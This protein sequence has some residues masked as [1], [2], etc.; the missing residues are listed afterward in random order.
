MTRA[1]DHG[2]RHAPSGFDIV[3][4][5]S[6]AAPTLRRSGRSHLVVTV[7]DVAWHRH[8]EATT[9]RGRRWHEFALT[10][11]RDGEA[12]LVVP[13]RLVAA[14]LAAFGVDPGRI[15]VVPG[16]A[17]HLPDPDLAA[18]EQL[19]GGLGVRGEFLLT[20]GT[21]EPRKN[22]DR[23]VRAFDLVRPS[24][25]EPWPLVIV[26]TGRVGPGAVARATTP[27]AVVFAGPVSDAVLAG[28]YRRARAFAYVP[29]TEGYGLP[30]LEAMQAGTPTVVSDEVP[31]V[32]DLGE[33]AAPPARIVD[34]L[35]IGDIAAGL[36]AVLTDDVLRADLLDPGSRARAVA[37]VGCRRGRAHRVVAVAAM[38]PALGLAL[39]VSA[40]PVHPGGAGYYT[41]ALA[42]GLSARTDVDLTLIARRGDEGRWNGLAAGATVRGAVPGSRPGRLA[43]EQVGLASVLRSLDVQ[44]HHGPHYTMPA[45][46]PVP[47][48]VTIHDCTFF[49]HPE[50]HLRSKAA[51]FR[52]AIRRAA[53][54]AGVL[55]CVS[56]VTADRLRACCEVRAPVVVAP[57]GVDHH[58]FSPAEPSQ[59]CRPGR[60]GR[61]RRARGP[62]ARRLRGHARAAQG[63]GAAG[64]CVRPAGRRRPGRRPG[65]RAASPGGGWPRPSGPWPPP[66]T[67]SGSS[68][69]GTCPTQAV[70]A[71]LRQAAVVAYPALEEGFGLP[72]LEALACG[73]PLVTTEGTR[74]GR[75]GAGGRPAGA[76]G[77]RRRAGR[78]TRDGPRVT[79]AADARAG[80][81]G[82]AVAGEHTWEASVALARGTPMR[83]PRRARQ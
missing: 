75:G 22:V 16:G 9:P 23:L 42:S 62:A 36:A 81:S 73:A 6:L 61:A 57:H 41:M 79:G 45:R 47:C 55:I 13:S 25:P 70:P 31:S 60:A 78:R 17:D 54:H 74:H 10:R 50:W 2:W 30:P 24:L 12:A 3:H 38:T 59:G 4:S 63:R 8:P 53:R 34:P 21:L 32:H 65:A 33:E 5:V 20:V 1:W 66:G 15:T 19:L 48:A 72:A 37:H 69:P 71:L 18:A 64:R 56:Q 29:L 83:W 11:A 77:R 28:L 35:D 39:D 67:P 68:A 58:R 51:F 40:V 46:S 49:D 7:H 80:R 52:R 44:V 26:G 14:D 27:T 76:A 82:L 43:F